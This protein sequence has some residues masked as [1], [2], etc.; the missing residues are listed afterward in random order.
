MATITTPRIAAHIAIIGGQPTTTTQDIADVYG[1]RHNDVLRI[2]RQRMN[3]VPEEWRLRNFAQTVIERA[4]PSGGAP[5]QSPAIRMSKK[6]FHFVV[7]KFTGAK[8][9]QHQLAF[10]DEFERMEG[11]LHQ[12]ALEQPP[13][14]VR[15]RLLSGQSNPPTGGYPARVERVI[16]EA[17]WRMA[18]EAY[19]LVREHLQRRVAFRHVFGAPVRQ[20]DVR[21][22]IVDL[23]KITLGHCLAREATAYTESAANSLR[24]VLRVAESANADMEKQLAELNS[25]E[26]RV[27]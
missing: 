18:H 15:K 19:G 1:K 4:N 26:S 23:R 21:G 17:A 22:A 20:I 24:M 12:P 5:I 11:Q 14:D 6:G 25:T 7:G 27:P 2:V 3:A 13:I 10:A 8:A 16:D 9:V